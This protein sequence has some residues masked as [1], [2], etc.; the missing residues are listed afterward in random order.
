MK[1]RKS[2]VWIASCF[3][4]VVLYSCANRVYVAK[5]VSAPY[6]TIGVILKTAI[7]P[8]YQIAAPHRR[9]FSAIKFSIIPEAKACATPYCDGTEPHTACPDGCLGCG[10]CPS[11]NGPCTAYTCIQ[12]TNFSRM[13]QSGTNLTPGDKCEGCSVADGVPCTSCLHGISCP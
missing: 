12:T 11:C 10:H 6:A 4:L 2:L 13:C 7:E 9:L 8:K 1:L 5:A 3:L